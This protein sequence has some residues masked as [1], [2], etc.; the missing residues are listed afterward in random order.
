MLLS[1]TPDRRCFFS[2]VRTAL[3]AGSVRGIGRE[4]R[5]LRSESPLNAG[6]IGCGQAA[7]EKPKFCNLAERSQ[8][9]QSF[10]GG[11]AVFG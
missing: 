11:P 4:D 6:G 9:T 7:F 5:Q 3:Y 8:K 1:I 2:S 10:Q